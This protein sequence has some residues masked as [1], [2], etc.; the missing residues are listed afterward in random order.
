MSF[1][2]V[3]ELPIEEVS[4]HYADQLDAAGWVLQVNLTESDDEDGISTY[5][6][7]HDENG[8]VW[9]VIFQISRNIFSSLYNYDVELRAVNPP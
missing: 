8:K 5:W 1:S 7:L 2:L 3:T 4:Q 6:E 9:L